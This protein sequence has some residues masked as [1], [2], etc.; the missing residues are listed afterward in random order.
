MSKKTISGGKYAAWLSDLKSRIVSARISAA[1]AV[2]RNLILLYWDIGCAIVEKQQSEGWGESVVEQIARDLTRA[3]PGI[4]GFSPRNLRD[5]TRFYLTYGEPAIWRQAGAKLEADSAAAENWRQAVAKLEGRS[6]ATANWRQAVAKLKKEPVKWMRQLVSEVPW[7]H[8]L[9]IL[10]KVDN[11]DARLFYLQATIRFGWTR[12][13]LL[14]Q[15]K[16]GAYKRSQKAGKTHN[17]PSVMPE[18]L[19]GQAAEALK[20]SYNLEFL[21]IGRELR[22]QELEKRLVDKLKEFILELGYGFCFVGQQYRLKLGRKEYYIDLLFYHR[23]LK[24]LVAVDL[25]LG[26][27]EPE[28]AGKMDFYL[29]LLNEKERASDDQP[30]I[31]IILCAEKDDLEVEFALKTKGNPIGVADYQ[32]KSSLPRELKGKLPNSKDL[33][34]ALGL[35]ERKGRRSGR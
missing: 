10:T 18:H 15:I 11:P 30:S 19:A 23:F 33:S 22:E 9:L 29:N 26:E 5:M 12:N 32:L 3:F 13:V 6:G 25:K 27:F 4:K 20:S 21:G 16:V 17:F 1:R 8:N 31:G 34:K 35:P 2:N 24:C 7:G 14:N 28:S